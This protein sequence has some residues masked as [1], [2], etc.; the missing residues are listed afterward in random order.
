MK[1][2]IIAIIIA[3]FL[4]FS[5]VLNAKEL[6]LPS[7]K[8]FKEK[9]EVEEKTS[10]PSIEEK[11][12]KALGMPMEGPG[13]GPGGSGEVGGGDVGSN[14]PLPIEDALCPMLIAGFLYIG[15]TSRKRLT[16]LLKKKN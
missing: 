10:L 1:I 7:K 6:Q 15:Y 4:S 2:K 16:V 8:F 9:I 5:F 13:S 3:S 14:P 11:G 12:I